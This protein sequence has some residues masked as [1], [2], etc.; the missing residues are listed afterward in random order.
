[1]PSARMSPIATSMT[2]REVPSEPLAPIARAGAATLTSIVAS[3]LSRFSQAGAPLSREGG[4][5]RQRWVTP[6]CI[7]L[8][9]GGG[10]D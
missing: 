3:P 7:S 10:H 1:M 2:T 6:A 8:Q 4:L 5:G 9:R